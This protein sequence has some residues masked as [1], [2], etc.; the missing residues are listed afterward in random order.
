M[1][2]R[3]PVNPFEQPTR[4]KKKPRKVNGKR[5]QRRKNKPAPQ[6]QHPVYLGGS[7]VAVIEG[8]GVTP[9]DIASVLAIHLGTATPQDGR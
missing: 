1:K 9:D 6:P 5:V 2:G 7:L 4:R 3:N 8:Y